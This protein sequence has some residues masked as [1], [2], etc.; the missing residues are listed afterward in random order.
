MKGAIAQKNSNLVSLAIKRDRRFPGSAALLQALSLSLLFI[1]QNLEGQ[2]VAT[3]WK[4][5]NSGF[6]NDTLNWDNGIPGGNTRNLFFGTGGNGR[7]NTTN[8]IS[9]YHGYRMTF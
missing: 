3:G 8:D 1:A 7:P 2:L 9:D 6:W 4:G 5:S